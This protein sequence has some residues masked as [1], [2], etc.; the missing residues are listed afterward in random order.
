MAFASDTDVVSCS[1]S[2]RERHLQPLLS[3]ISRML[4]ILYEKKKSIGWVLYKDQEW[5]RSLYTVGG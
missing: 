4:L 3:V 2:H 5:G 1:A